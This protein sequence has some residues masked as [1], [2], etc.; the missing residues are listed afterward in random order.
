MKAL[1]I[2][3]LS[4]FSGAGLTFLS[5]VLLARGLSANEY[6]LF[7]TALTTVTLVTPLAGFGVGMFW[8]KAFGE[9]GRQAVRWLKPSIYF[10]VISSVTAICLIYIW[11]WWPSHDPVSSKL[12]HILALYVVGQAVIELVSA[13]FQLEEKYF[14]LALWQFSL[15]A[16]R[17]SVLVLFY[18]MLMDHLSVVS[19]GVIYACTSLLTFF[20]GVTLLLLVGR[21]GIALKGHEHTPWNADYTS[22]PGMLRVLRECWP[23]GVSGVFYLIY[24]QSSVVLVKFMAGNEAAALYGVAIVLMSAIYIFPG[25]LYQKLLLPKI[26]RWANY[27]V[28]YLRKVYEKGNWG[29]FL[30]GCLTAIALYVLSP[31]VIPFIFGRSYEP[32]ISLIRIMAF[33]VPFR[34]LATSVGAMLATKSHMKVKVMIMGV[35]GVLSVATNAAL[36]SSM[37]A[38]GA[39]YAAVLT[40]GA[41]FVFYCFWV[42]KLV[43]KKERSAC[44]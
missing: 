26:H 42:G 29:M 1:F 34:F 32:V 12:L 39:A 7:F 44:L 25:V 41:L 10:T 23:F 43:F 9:E 31:L 8:L 5:Q 30:L 6:G 14:Q 36:I 33:A 16:L 3:T 27:D 22:T 21:R 19:V 35:V 40:D 17:F 28:A 20:C 15:P 37:G 4:S 18:F 2:L 38:K 24:F 11:G 13:V